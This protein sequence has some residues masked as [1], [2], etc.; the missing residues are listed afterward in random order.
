M[1]AV[2]QHRL[3]RA[4]QREKV[5][6]ISIRLFEEGVRKILPA[7]CH[8]HELYKSK[9]TAGITHVVLKYKIQNQASFD[10][11]SL[12]PDNVRWVLVRVLKHLRKSRDW[13]QQF[14]VY[15]GYWR[16]SFLDYGVWR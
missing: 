13:S 3:V 1:V 12:E 6:S 14:R 4:K 10:K 5:P 16:F 7:H 8:G 15:H 11:A 2:I 9:V